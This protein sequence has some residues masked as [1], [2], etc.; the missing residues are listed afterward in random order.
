MLSTV[1]SEQLA[2]IVSSIVRASYGEKLDILNSL[3]LEERFEKAFPLLERQ[4]EGLKIARYNLCQQRI[5]QNILSIY[6]KH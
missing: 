1:P 5:T 6:F 4:I 2:D 3:T